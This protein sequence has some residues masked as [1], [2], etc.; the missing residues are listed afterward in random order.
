MPISRTLKAYL[1][2]ERAYAVLP[3]PEAFRAAEIAHAL[4]K[5]RKK[6]WQR[7]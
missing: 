7:L 6:K 3:H 2:H 1:N 4:S 5:P